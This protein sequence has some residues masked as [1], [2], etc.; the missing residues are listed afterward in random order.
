VQCTFHYS[1]LALLGVGLAT[2]YFFGGE[3][4]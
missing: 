4:G 1:I 2:L 3:Y